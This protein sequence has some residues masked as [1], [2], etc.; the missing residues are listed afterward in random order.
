MEDW[1]PRHVEKEESK[2]LGIA[3]GWYGAKVSGTFV[4]GPSATRQDC[5]VALSKLTGIPIKVARE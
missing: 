2:R 1:S 4:T 3:H 5:L